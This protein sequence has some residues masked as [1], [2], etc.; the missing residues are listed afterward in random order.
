MRDRV[1][2][3]LGLVRAAYGG[4]STGPNESW[5]RIDD[6]NLIPGWNRRSTSILIEIPIGYPTVS[7]DN[8]L[9]RADLRLADGRVPSNT[10][11]IKTIDGSK[12]LAFSH[13][14]E[15]ESWKAHADPSQSHTLVDYVAGVLERLQECS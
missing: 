8:F 3:E 11:G 9:T 14:A 1:R 2:E 6:A 10:M 13:H 15:A 4:A 12:W 5:V 7:P